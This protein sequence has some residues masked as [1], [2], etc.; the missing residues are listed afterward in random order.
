MKIDLPDGL[1]GGGF[2]CL[3]VGVWLLAG[4]GAVCA[5]AGLALIAVGLLLGRKA[6]PS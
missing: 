3:L 1:V 5:V 4:F 2:V 6:R